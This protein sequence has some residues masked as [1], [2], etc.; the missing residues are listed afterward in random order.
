MVLQ[1]CR[2]A[3]HSKCR[4]CA[5]RT[6][7]R[8]GF[9]RPSALRR[10][11]KG[12]P[13]AVLPLNT[14]KLPSADTEGHGSFCFSTSSLRPIIAKRETLVTDQAVEYALKASYVHEQF[15]DMRGALNGFIEVIQQLGRDFCRIAALF[16]PTQSVILFPR[17]I[18]RGN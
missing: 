10:P 14:R 3:G 15:H 6:P 17:P 12:L 7:T 13:F 18:N 4:A 8:Y 1:A 16:Y 11:Q 5:V 9:P 2:P